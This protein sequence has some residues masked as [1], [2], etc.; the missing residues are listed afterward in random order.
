MMAS[1]WTTPSDLCG[2]IIDSLDH[3][4]SAR[5]LMELCSLEGAAAGSSEHLVLER[6]SALA[7]AP[8]G[9]ALADR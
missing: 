4:S 9:S 2:A 5:R 1:E 6:R 8:R 3:R 7:V